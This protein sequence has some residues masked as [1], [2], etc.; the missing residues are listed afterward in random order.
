VIV[1][2]LQAEHLALRLVQLDGALGRFI[3]AGDAIEYRGLAGAVR[4]DQ[5]GDV[6]AANI[7]RHVVDRGEPA[8][9]HSEVLDPE[10][11]IFLPGPHALPSSTR[12]LGMGRALA[13]AMEGVREPMMPRGRHTMMPTMATPNSSMR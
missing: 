5:G 9:P 3:E 4:A 12:S 7:E 2:P 8:E 6:V 10:Q 13:R 1:E 11:P